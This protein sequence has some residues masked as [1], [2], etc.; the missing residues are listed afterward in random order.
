MVITFLTTSF[1]NHSPQRLRVDP[2]GRLEH[3]RGRLLEHLGLTVQPREVQTHEQRP[4]LHVG[5][6]V[7]E[8]VRDGLGD[9]IG[10]DRVRMTQGP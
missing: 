4:G 2:G 7:G 10:R 9:L 3:L 5:H 8:E 6:L 1:L